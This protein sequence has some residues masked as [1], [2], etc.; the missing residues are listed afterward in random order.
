MPYKGKDGSIRKF[1]Y[2][3][4]LEK[5]TRCLP[6][7][8]ETISHLIIKQER[9]IFLRNFI[10]DNPFVRGSNKLSHELLARREKA[11]IKML[12]FNRNHSIRTMLKTESKRKTSDDLFFWQ[13]T[14]GIMDTDGSFSIKKE[15]NGRFQPQIL[16]TMADCRAICYVMN[17]FV[18]GKLIVVK[19]KTTK[20]G[21]CY[22]FYIQN[23][24]SL[25]VFLQKVIPYLFIKKN[26]AETLLEYCNTIKLVKNRRAG[27][28][29]EEKNKRQRYYEIICELNKN[30]VYKSPLIDLK[31]LPGKA[32]DNRAQA[33]K[34]CSVNVVSEETPKGDAVL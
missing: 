25:I 30:G 15:K 27:I 16:L 23:R 18:G 26:V 6:F 34:S 10:I 12:T 21:F 7:L 31:L 33:E 28:Q 5:S 4:K 13:Y 24:E 22:R 8:E 19:A 14:A 9:A 1:S 17:N 32:E 20:N 29:Q 3:W 2:Q 11:Y